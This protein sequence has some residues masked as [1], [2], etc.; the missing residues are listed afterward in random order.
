M[1][2]V[3]WPRG[4]LDPQTPCFRRNGRRCYV[5]AHTG[6]M[7]FAAIFCK[8]TNSFAQAEWPADRVRETFLE[9]FRSK[10]RCAARFPAR[11]THTGMSSA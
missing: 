6:D 4:Q 3:T 9:Y 1:A 10:A 2:L 11:A 8:K 5:Q 7:S